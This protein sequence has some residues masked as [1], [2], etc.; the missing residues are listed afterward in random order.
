MML[1]VAMH[2]VGGDVIPSSGDWFLD[3]SACAM[4]RVMVMVVVV[5][6]AMVVFVVM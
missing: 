3:R 1:A 4:G 2:N 6:V 5:V